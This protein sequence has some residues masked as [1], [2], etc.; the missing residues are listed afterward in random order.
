MDILSPK[1]E[2]MYIRDALRSQVQQLL[3]TIR[4]G[5]LP[6]KL[7]FALNLIYSFH[8]RSNLACPFHGLLQ[9][10]ILSFVRSHEQ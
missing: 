2:F 5:T 3:K 1:P 6:K 7:Y 10:T 8:S 9:I 4:L